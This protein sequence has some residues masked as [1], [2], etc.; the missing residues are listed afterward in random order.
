MPAAL[1]RV[2]VG[3]PAQGSFAWRIA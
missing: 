3:K 2:L 1:R